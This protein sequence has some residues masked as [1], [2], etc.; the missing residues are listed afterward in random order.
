MASLMM[1]L[2]APMDFEGQRKAERLI[3]IIIT[4][5]GCVGLVFGWFQQEY[6]KCVYTI[7]AGIALCILLVVPNWP[8]YKGTSMKWV[9][10]DLV[11]KYWE[12]EAE[13]EKK[14][15]DNGD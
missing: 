13:K 7:F 15:K 11:D 8:Y 6:S 5:C 2:S 14:D 9:D 12:E 1:N 10:D 4:T 3:H